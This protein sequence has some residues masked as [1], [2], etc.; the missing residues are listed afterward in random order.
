MDNPIYTPLADFAR[1]R[2]I[3][4]ARAYQLKDK[5]QLIHLPVYAKD[6]GS[7]IEILLCKDGSPLLHT[8]VVQDRNDVQG[9][10]DAVNQAIKTCNGCDLKRLQGMQ[11][12]IKNILK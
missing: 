3:S 12:E 1:Q 5:L 2:G 11:K 7:G 6:I 10:L 8:F 9:E 4:R